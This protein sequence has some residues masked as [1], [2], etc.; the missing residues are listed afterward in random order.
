MLSADRPIGPVGPL[1]IPTSEIE[2]YFRI[3]RISSQTK[4]DEVLRAV[5]RIDGVFLK[6]C[7]DTRE[8]DEKAAK[9]KK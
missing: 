9:A 8:A 5:R 6:H 3:K 7:Q 4:Q 2:S 1:S